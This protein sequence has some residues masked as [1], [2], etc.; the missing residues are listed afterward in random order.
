MRPTCSVCKIPM[1][2]SKSRQTMY[3]TVEHVC[4][5]C[6]RARYA[7]IEQPDLGSSTKQPNLGS[8]TKSR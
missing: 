6:G 2:R 4:P 7:P 3:G 5:K 8:S 1:R